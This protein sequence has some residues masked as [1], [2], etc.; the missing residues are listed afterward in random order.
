[1]GNSNIPGPDHGIIISNRYPPALAGRQRRKGGKGPEIIPLPKRR[2]K[3]SY[4]IKWG[5]T[6]TKHVLTRYDR[7]QN[8]FF[9]FQLLLFADQDRTENSAKQIG[10]PTAEVTQISHFK[11]FVCSIQIKHNAPSH[12]PTEDWPYKD[13]KCKIPNAICP[14]SYI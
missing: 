13:E 10:S 7:M 14:T 6:S 3:M 1:M 9:P 5:R 2:Q 8:S 12:I 4:Q 11:L